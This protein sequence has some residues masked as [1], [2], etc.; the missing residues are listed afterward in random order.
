MLKIVDAEEPPLR[1]F[2]GKLPIQLAKADYESRIETWE[3]WQPVAEA[4][5]GLSHGLRGRRVR[6]PC[7][8]LALHGLVVAEQLVAD[9]GPG[10][11]Q[12]AAARGDRVAR[13]LGDQMVDGLAT[14]ALRT[15]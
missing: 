5:A 3:E 2:F 6:R 12:D 13:P 14:G 15:R 7:S 10:P 8:D 11:A 4:R 1:V 9:R